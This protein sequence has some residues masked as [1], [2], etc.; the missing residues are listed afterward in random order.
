MLV[1][2]FFIAHPRGQCANSVLECHEAFSLDV[3]VI[4]P[5]FL[6]AELCSFSVQTLLLISVDSDLLT[7]TALENASL[8][9]HQIII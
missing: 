6:H 8:P 1:D 7:V 2:V 3:L 9:Q 5:E 4:Q